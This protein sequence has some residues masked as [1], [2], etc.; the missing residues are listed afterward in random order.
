MKRKIVK[1]FRTDG[2]IYLIYVYIIALIGASITFSIAEKV[3]LPTAFWWGIVTTTTVGY[4]D[5]S[6]A[7]PIGKIAAVVLMFV[8]ISFIGM[9][10]S[11]ITTYFGSNNL[12][13]SENEI[14]D[15]IENLK[16]ENKRLMVKIDQL[17]DKISDSLKN[18]S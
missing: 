5:I 14:I 15:Q 6:P 13:Q 1:F 11:A 9:L 12:N 8:G 17:N 16:Q 3:S 2:F 18:K 7:T 10:A 4:G